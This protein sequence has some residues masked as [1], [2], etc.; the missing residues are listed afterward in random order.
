MP[1]SPLFAVL[2]VTSI[3]TGM[4][5][6]LFLLPGG[7]KGPIM[8]NQVAAKPYVEKKESPSSVATLTIDPQVRANGVLFQ[9]LVADAQSKM[10]EHAKYA[11]E[12][13]TLM[14]PTSQRQLGFEIDWRVT[15][16]SDR[17]IS[18]DKSTYDNGGGAHPNFYLNSL[19]WDKQQEKNISLA[20]LLTDSSENSAALKML[21]ANLFEQ[22]K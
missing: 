10:A 7:G 20:E 2:V 6:W 21:S 12:T 3:L 18:L 19:L 13:W 4:G 9:K 14:G 5:I 17:L 16:E 15:Y 1:K 8:A 11:A 22:W